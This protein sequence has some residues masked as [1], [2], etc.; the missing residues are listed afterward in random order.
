MPGWPTPSR[1]PDT[2]RARPRPR[3]GGGPE[4]VARMATVAEMLHGQ[5]RLI[6]N[7]LIARWIAEVR[8]AAPSA[9]ARGAG[10]GIQSATCGFRL[11]A[12]VEGR[13]APR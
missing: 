8:P 9:A 6:A 5:I 10:R 3:T 7:R 13:P 11:G 4:D 1:S 12:P 2:F